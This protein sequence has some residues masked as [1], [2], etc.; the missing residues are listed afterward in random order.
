M[1]LLERIIGITTY[2]VIMLIVVYLVYRLPKEKL[3]K[4]LIIYNILLF[5]MAYFYIPATSADLYRLTN[6]MKYYASFGISDLPQLLLNSKA[7]V[8]VLYSYIIGK[9]GID[10]LL[11]AITSLIFYSN[12]FIIFYKSSKKLNLSNK[13]TAMSLLLFMEMGKFLE[14]ISGIRTMLAF[15]FIA[16]CCYNEFIEKKSVIKD[17]LFYLIASLIH[18]AAMVLALIR[19]IFLLF[20]KEG[21]ILKRLFNFILLIIISG[22][23]IKYGKEYLDLIFQKADTYLNGDVYS[24]VWEYAISWI[25]ILFS[26]YS[27][28]FRKKDLVSNMD[29]NNLR[30]FNLF[31]N[32]IILLF[33]FEYSIF[34]RYQAFSNMI[35]IPIIGVILN[36]VFLE[37]SIRNRKYMFIVIMVSTLLFFI[38]GLRGNLSGYKYLLFE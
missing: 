37:K 28:L 9:I 17:I 6:T 25:C 32:V 20:Q 33:S 30:K 13:S 18:P 4:V 15:S 21:K 27:L 26:T 11:P 10:N 7:P 34:S 36:N 12:I 16:L 29:L 14:V 1:Y 38:V 5:I 24:Y 2:M 8:Y 3:K 23:M 35:F 19:M 31:I 22:F